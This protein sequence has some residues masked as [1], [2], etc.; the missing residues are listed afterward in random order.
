MANPHQVYFVIQWQEQGPLDARGRRL[1]RK[2]QAVC[3]IEDYPR[4]LSCHNPKCEGG[5]FEIGDKIVAL[6]ASEETNEQNSLICRNAIHKDHNKRCLHIIAY[7]I[8][9]FTTGQKLQND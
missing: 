7:S 3:T 2:D 1:W 9:C 6:Q 5:G 8:T 4:V